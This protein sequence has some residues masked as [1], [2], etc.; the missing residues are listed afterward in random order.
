[1]MGMLTICLLRSLAQTDGKYEREQ[2]ARSY[3]DWAQS[4]PFHIGRTTHKALS[5]RGSELRGAA[6]SVFDAAV[7]NRGPL[8]FSAISDGTQS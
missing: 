6:N 5:V 8:V 3:V 4:E 1:M 7:A 2:V